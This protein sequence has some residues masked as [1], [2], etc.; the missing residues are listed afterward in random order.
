MY[1]FAI[2]AELTRHAREEAPREACGVVAGGRYHRLANLSREDDHFEMDMRGFCRIA[3]KTPVEAIC[4]SHVGHGPAPSDLDRQGCEASRL[5]WLILSWP[6]GDIAELQPC[7]WRDP[8][9]GRPWAWGSSDC[10]SLV[11]DAFRHHAGISIPDVPRR[12]G[13]WHQHDLIG[14][15]FAACGFREVEDELQHLD[16]LAM[17]VGAERPNHLALYLAPGS[18]LHQLIH[19]PSVRSPYT[20]TLKRLTVARFRHEAL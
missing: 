2:L 15:Q 12:W 19:Q 5:P 8:F 17:T 9:V 18:I 7:G 14:E 6:S 1:D 11:R 10:F 20:G 3:S 13:F 16:V 4:H